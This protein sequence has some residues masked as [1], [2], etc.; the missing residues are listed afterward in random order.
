MVQEATNDK[1][2]DVFKTVTIDE[3]PQKKPEKKEKRK[4]RKSSAPKKQPVVQQ[5]VPKMT[6]QVK[7][8]EKKYSWTVQ[9]KANLLQQASGQDLNLILELVDTM[10]NA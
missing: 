8:E 5:E 1:K 9:N 2:K 4:S 6:D 3:Q 7:P 10:P